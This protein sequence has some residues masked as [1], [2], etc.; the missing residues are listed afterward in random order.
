MRLP[1]TA[2]LA[3]AACASLPDPVDRP[4]TWRPAGANEANLR[5]MVV[6]P[7]HLTRGVSAPDSDGALAARPVGKLLAGERATL[8]DPR[9]GQRGLFGGG[10][11]AAR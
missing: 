6:E 4:G 9:T 1:L 8:P 3:L 11:N 5:Q 10:A 2:F 7:A